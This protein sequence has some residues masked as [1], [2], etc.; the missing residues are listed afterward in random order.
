VYLI[1]Q[2]YDQGIEEV[3]KRGM[4]EALESCAGDL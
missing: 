4:L 1:E 3:A 2:Q